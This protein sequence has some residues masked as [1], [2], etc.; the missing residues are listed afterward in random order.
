[1]KGVILIYALLFFSLLSA[2]ER[3]VY[4]PQEQL[5]LEQCE[6][7]EN[8]NSCLYSYYD[9]KIQALLKSK[10]GLKLLRQLDSD[11]L[12]TGGFIVVTKDGQIIKDKSRLFLK[13]KRLN[14][15]LHPAFENLFFQESF[16]KV[17]NY[18]TPPFFATHPFSFDYAITRSKDIISLRLLANEEGYSGGVIIEVPIFPGCE[19]VHPSEMQ[20]CFQQKIEEHIKYHFRYPKKAL[21]RGISGTVNVMIVI[22]KNGA[23]SE[24]KAKG[25]H[26]LLESEALRIVNLL[27]KMT[28]AK[29]NGKTAKI[30]FSFPMYF[31]LK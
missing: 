17:R 29:K 2:Q 21:N 22:D 30:P 20:P 10:K 24:S 15:K 18:K 27:P 14:D 26:E 25:P 31:K 8:P 4:F 9:Q 12:K 28:P 16:K 19:A 5:I 1:M 7:T 13:N 3:L 6:N 11:T 23:I